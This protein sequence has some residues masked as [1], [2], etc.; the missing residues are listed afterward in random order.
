MGADLRVGAALS[1]AR[2]DPAGDDAGGHG[3]GPRRLCRGDAT[4]GGGWMRLARAPLRA[5]LSAVELSVAAHQLA[6]RRIRRRRLNRARYPLEV[7]RAM[8]A[9]WPEDRPMSVRLS[10]HDWTQGGNTPDDAA[11]FAGMFKEAGADLID[12]SSGQV[13]KASGR[14][15]AACSRRRS[16]TRSATR[17][18]SPPSRSAPSPKPTTPIRSS[19]PAA[20]IFARSRGR[21]SPIPPGRCTKPPR[22]AWPTSP[23]PKQYHSAKAQYEANLARG[24]RSAGCGDMT[25]EAARRPSRARDRRGQRHRRGDRA[26]LSPGRRAGE[27]GGASRAPL[28]DVA[29]DMPQGGRPRSSSVRRDVRAA[30][31]RRG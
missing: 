21:I 9:A 29:R 17:R 8:R 30:V 26:L 16:P 23:G 1:A 7:F 25:D 11:I 15:T 14:S 13:S 3:P 5:R 22:S 19:R 24:G 10:C 12:C 4:R 18:R 6:Q 31:V 20:P 2:L 28:E 27:P